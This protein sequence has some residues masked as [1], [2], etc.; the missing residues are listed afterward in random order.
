MLVERTQESIKP[1]SS[2]KA[3]MP[4]TF[5]RYASEYSSTYGFFMPEAAATWDFLLGIQRDYGFAG[6]FLEIGVL[7]G[8]SAYLA[9]LHLR[10]G[11]PCTLAVC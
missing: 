11:E 9:A 3:E 4:A 1:G 2:M 5:S 8:K 7:N 6:G 10:A